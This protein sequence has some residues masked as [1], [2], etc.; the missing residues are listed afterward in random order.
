MLDNVK[1][2]L[3]FRVRE[4]VSEL[5]DLG[6]V[7]LRDFLGE[8]GRE[9]ED[10]Y[11]GGRGGWVRLRREAG[12]ERRPVDDVQEDGKLAKA[13][14]RMLHIDDPERLSFLREVL[15]A[16]SPPKW[17]SADARRQRPRD[18]PDAV[19]LGVPERDPRGFA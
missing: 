9:L 7:G 13:I 1:R 10:L 16:P 11:E 8:T 19:P 3:G 6:D 2:S 18:H 4:A 17:A 14:G 12:Y 15:D 5:R